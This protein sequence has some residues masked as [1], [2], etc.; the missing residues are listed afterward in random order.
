LKDDDGHETLT[1]WQNNFLSK[2][3]GIEILLKQDEKRTAL[4]GSI[5]SRSGIRIL[6]ATGHR[7]LDLWPWALGLGSWIVDRGYSP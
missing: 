5:F 3:F 6:D 2:R 7:I 4:I 1:G